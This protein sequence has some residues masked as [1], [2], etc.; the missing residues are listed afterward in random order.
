MILLDVAPFK[1]ALKTEG[2]VV[3]VPHKNPDGDALGSC[4]ALYHFLTNQGFECQVIAPNG[5]P[6]FLSWLPG[7]EDILIAENE[8]ENAEDYVRRASLIFTLDFNDLS[9]CGALEE[10]I[11]AATGLKLMIDHHIDPKS[12]A[13]VIYS[14]TQMSSTCEM[15][16]NLITNLADQTALTPAISSCLYTGIITDTGSFKYPAATSNTLR[17]AAELVDRGA[18]KTLIAQEL[19]DQGHLSRFKLMGRCIDSLEVLEPYSTALMYV[20]EKDKYEC[21]FRKG[22]TE[23]FVNMGLQLKGIHFSAIFIEHA[24]DRMIKISF[25]SIGDFDVNAFARAHFNGGGHKNAAGGRSD[26][27][28]E[29]TLKQFKSLL[30]HYLTTLKSPL[31]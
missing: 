15:V 10:S 22:D 20:T 23:G 2:S 21:H 28:L 26:S 27:T 14:D 11:S 17:I 4:L 13:E 7:S 19:F 25:R 12:Y 31:S 16:Y 8:L 18:D 24:E 3:I 6:D 29:E 30:P 1:Q 5:Y 9:R